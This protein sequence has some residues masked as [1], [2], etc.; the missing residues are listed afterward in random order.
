M[1]SDNDGIDVQQIIAEVAARHDL[2]LKPGDPAIVLVTMNRLILDSTIRALHEQ[3][4]ATISEFQA[5]IE[6]AETR[7]GD[8][9]AQR[10]KE[11][12]SQMR[13][14]LEKDIDLAGVKARELVSL[15]N[16][17]HRR[18]ALIRWSAV[19]LIAGALLF[20]CGI[21]LGTLLH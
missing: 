9:L 5:S 14:E 12:S 13:K 1:T 6:K 18:P 8:V 2:F 3:I 21:W 15:V 10:V 7:A 19:G 16:E 17:A 4:R 20:G 11:S